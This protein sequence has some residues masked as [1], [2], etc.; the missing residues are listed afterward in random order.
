MCND[1]DFIVQIA[2]IEDV[3]GI[4]N[5]LKAN[6]I[7]IS[8]FEKI[9]K[10]ARK[11]LEEKGFLR[12]EV[13]KQ[14]YYEM[15]GNKQ[16]DI[17]IAKD[18]TEKILGFASIHKNQ[19]DVRALRS[20]L[21]NLYV[22]DP[23]ILNLLTKKEKKF[24]YL[25]QI[26]ILPECKRRG[27]GKAIIAEALYKLHFPVVAFIVEQPLAN[28]ASAYW[29]EKCGFELVGTCDGSYKGKKFEWKIYL[30]WNNEN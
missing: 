18:S 9:S 7:E 2:T 19:Y 28:K 3:N 13:D 24:A 8:D 15:I 10:K 17:Y 27:I 26:S 14:Y 6:L 23:E 1:A 29:H 16:C 5:A 11:E 25:D 20:T 4:H 30:N 12:K 21:D 22:N